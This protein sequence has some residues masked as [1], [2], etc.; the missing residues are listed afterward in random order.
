MDEVLLVNVMRFD[1]C[2]IDHGIL[3]DYFHLAM[4]YTHVAG[5]QGNKVNSLYYNTEVSIVEV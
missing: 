5:V 1:L 4:I 2:S 3:Q